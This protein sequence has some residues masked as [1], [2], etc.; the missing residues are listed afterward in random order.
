MNK[1][2]ETT[3]RQDAA[4][5]EEAAK[6]ADVVR[7]I[8]EQRLKLEGQ[9]PATADHQE[10]ADAIQVILQANADSFYSALDQPYFGR[11]DYFHRRA[12]QGDAPTEAPADD[13]PE[14]LRTI[15]LGIVFIRGKDVFSWTSPVGRLWYTQSMDDGYTAPRGYIATRVDLKRY[16][17]IRNQNLEGVS[18]IF[19]RLPPAPSPEQLPAPSSEQAPDDFEGREELLREAVS[20]VGSGDGH[21]QVIIETIEPEQYENIANVSDRVLIVQGAAGSGKSEIGLHRIAFLLSPF[22]DLPEAERPTP[23]TTLF[24]GPSQAFLDYAADI[25]PTLGLQEGVQRV[26]FSE[27][28]LGCLSARTPARARIWSNLLDRGELTRYDE[29]AETFKGSLAMAD[30]LEKYVAATARETRN[31]CLGLST[32][33]RGPETTYETTAAEIRSALNVV[34]QQ[35][36][37]GRGLNERRAQFI[38]RVAS[39]LQASEQGRPR[40]NSQELPLEALRRDQEWR[41]S[42]R[43]VVARWCDGAWPHINFRDAYFALLADGE[44]MSRLAGRDLPEGVGEELAR[45]AAGGPDSGVDDADLGA[46]AYLDHLLNNTISPTY[47]HIVVDEAQDISPIEFKLL[48]ASSLNNW[49]TVLGDTAQRLTPYRGVRGWR[50]VE[51]VFGRAEIEVQRARRSYRSSRQITLF[52]NRILRTFDANI[53][54]PI[55]FEREGHRVEYSRYRNRAEMYQGIIDDIDRIRSLENMSDAVV[56]ILVRDQANLNQFRRFCEERGLG[57]IVLVGQEQHTRSRTVVGRI[58]DVKGLE[59]DAVIVMGVND[60]FS[61]TL[62]NKKL[63]YM[64]TTRAKH[65]LGIHWNGRQSP[66]L[67]SISERGVRRYRR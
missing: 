13:P 58:P 22:N 65:Y 59:Y 48:S 1:P 3:Q 42:I 33:I 20:G 46:L 29:A 61:D 18:D 21:L 47:R 49:F 57:E 12:E 32:E 52:N 8:E 30:V 54:A 10:A 39:S 16:I 19:R 44:R 4:F 5:A 66:I 28:L 37:R 9:M 45:T 24:V 41:A 23:E 64:A 17:R 34:L 2:R 62:F 27:W 7:H 53:P 56:A 60:A 25:L 26:R 15:Y 50:D 35:A 6:L 51:R 55:P 43:D 31:R 11:L 36:E 67:A 14:P 63:L 40:R 38:E